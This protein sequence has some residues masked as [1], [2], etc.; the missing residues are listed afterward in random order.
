MGYPSWLRTYL[1]PT[2]EAS[3]ATSN[4][5]LKF[6]RHRIGGFP[7]LYLISSNALFAALIEMNGPDF[8]NLVIGAMI[9]LKF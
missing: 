4:A 9:L 3:Q 8:I 7:I 5:F 6:G 1:V 2:R